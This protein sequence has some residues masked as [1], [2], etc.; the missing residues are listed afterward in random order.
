MAT[1]NDR[2]WYSTRDYFEYPFLWIKTDG[3]VGM[4]CNGPDIPTKDNYQTAWTKWGFPSLSSTIV[5][6]ARPIPDLTCYVPPAAEGPML[7]VGRPLALS[8]QGLEE[9]IE[10]D[11]N[12]PLEM[13]NPMPPMPNLQALLQPSSATTCYLPAVD[14]ISCDEPLRSWPD[15]ITGLTS[16][17]YQTDYIPQSLN[18]FSATS[19]PYG[20]SVTTTANCTIPRPSPSECCFRPAPLQELATVD[21]VPATKDQQ[22]ER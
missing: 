9:T 21:A 4:G 5:S 17:A 8:V 2:P 22:A 6:D 15:S 3:P 11:K 7:H 14:L 20:T 18:V 12:L 1:L 10:N 16:N 13:Q 19:D